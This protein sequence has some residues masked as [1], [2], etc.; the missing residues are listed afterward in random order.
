MVTPQQYRNVTFHRT[1]NGKGEKKKGRYPEFR[2]GA[3]MKKDRG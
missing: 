1:Q 3:E 2:Y